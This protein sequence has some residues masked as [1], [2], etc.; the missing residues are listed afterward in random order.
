MWGISIGI[1]IIFFIIIGIAASTVPKGAIY[2]TDPDSIQGITEFI[3]LKQGSNIV[4][5]FG[6]IN[7][8]QVYASS[9][10]MVNLGSYPIVEPF[11]ILMILT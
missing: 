6:L 8:D 3:V 10:A 7:T 11:Y 1:V 5:R 4:D 2:K 9:D